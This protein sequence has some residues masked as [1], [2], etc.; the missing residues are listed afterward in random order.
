MKATKRMVWTGLLLSAFTASPGS[1]D[2]RS[3][4]WT[5]D[6]MTTARGTAELETYFTLSTPDLGALEGRTT[7]EHQV[8]IEVGMTDRFDFAVYQV[9]AQEPG[10]D[11]AYRGFKLRARYR[12]SEKGRSVFDP[13]VYLEYRGSQDLAEQAVEGKLVLARDLGRFRLALNPTLE[14][15]REESEWE[16]VPEYALGLSYA[17][18][19]LLRLGIEAKGSS[20]GHYVGPVLAHGRENLWMTAG[21]AVEAGAVDQGKP[22]LQ[23]RVLMGIAF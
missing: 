14:L 4:V 16:A 5:Y 11:L 6:Y 12:L 18:K 7:A 17:L 1:S 9:F 23:V 3:F 2:Q 10:S 15:E 13:L 8:E 20:R 19:P 22:E 21:A